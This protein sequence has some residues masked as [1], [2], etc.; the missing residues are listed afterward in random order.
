MNNVIETVQ[1]KHHTINVVWDEDPLHPRKDWDVCSVFLSCHPR[2]SGDRKTDSEEIRR[3]LQHPDQYISLPVYAYI[4]SGISLSTRNFQDPWDSGMIGCVYITRDR[5]AKEG[6]DPEKAPQY[7]AS[8]VEALSQYLSGEC[9]GYTIAN[10]E[11]GEEVGSCYG[12]L[13]NAEYAK[14]SALAEATYL[15]KKI[16]DA[17]AFEKYGMAL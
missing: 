2:V 8:E 9:Y 6:I 12:F 14:T 16:D 17:I 4:H 3:I 7:L 10:N 15:D 11:S 13:G 1:T 5:C